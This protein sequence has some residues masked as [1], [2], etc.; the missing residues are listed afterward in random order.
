MLLYASP[1]LQVG[2]SF[3]NRG[4]Y[5]LLNTQVP[6]SSCE[7]EQ[8]VAGLAAAN[9]VLCQVLDFTASAAILMTIC[10]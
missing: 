3:K 4:V 9:Y 2:I 1:S 7:L 6:C 10:T 8:D 5:L